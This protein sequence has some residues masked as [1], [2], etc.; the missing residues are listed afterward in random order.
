MLDRSVPRSAFASAVKA[1]LPFLERLERGVRPRWR[2]TTSPAAKRFLGFFIL[3]MAAII[4]LP[5]PFTN[6]PCAIAIF[7]IGLGLAERDGTLI[8][9][10]LVLGIALI[11]AM[12]IAAVGIL[13]LFGLAPEI[14]A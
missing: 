7:M 13:S 11:A 6:M 10:G 14:V 12:G 4:A 1:I 8:A 5:I 3:L 2:W 9:L